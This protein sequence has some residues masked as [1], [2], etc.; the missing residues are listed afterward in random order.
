MKLT[1]PPFAPYFQKLDAFGELSED[2]D[3][4][5]AARISSRAIATS[6]ALMSDLSLRT[7]GGLEGIVPISIAPVATGGVKIEWH[8]TD[9]AL[10]LWIDDEGRIERLL[11]RKNDHPRFDEVALSG[12]PAAVSEVL[13]F[14]RST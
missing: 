6:R 7:A 2:W 3:S 10:E 13:K 11:D 14:C 4:Y 8:R 5:G 12:I 9:A 1:E